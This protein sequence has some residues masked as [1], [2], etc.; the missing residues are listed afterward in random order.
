MP[1]TTGPVDG[2]TVTGVIWEAPFALA[3]MVATCVVGVD[4]APKN[5]AL[6][7]A[8]GTVTEGGTVSATLLDVNVTLVPEAGAALASVTVQVA[9]DPDTMLEGLHDTEDTPG[10]AVVT[11]TVVVWEAPPPVAVTVTVC[12]VV[13]DP[14]PV[15]V[16]LI[17]V[18]GT[19]T[20]GGT[21]SAELLDPNVTIR[22][23]VGAALVSVTV[24]VLFDPDTM[25]AGLHDTAD[26]A[27][28]GGVTVTVVVLEAPPAVAVT[29]AVCV[30]VVEPVPV[31]VAV[32]VVAVTVTEGGTLSAVLLDP[33]VTLVPPVGAAIVSVTVQVVLDPDTMLAG[34]HDTVDTAGGAG[35]TVTVVV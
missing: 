30:V 10:V 7:L 14:A 11:E 33:K 26:T 23:P 35:V 34:L 3:V 22:P 15:N 4:P 29:V 13:V 8:A 28:G 20:E 1:T 12:V 18:A 16:V 27:G 25:L 5:V 17:V 2:V 6:V 19:V 24:Q 31:N 9:L 21:V 32:V